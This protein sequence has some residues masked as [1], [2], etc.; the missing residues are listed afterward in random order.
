[1]QWTN[2]T[3]WICSTYKHAACPFSSWSAL[4]LQRT[5]LCFVKSYLNPCIIRGL[6]AVLKMGAEK[7][8]SWAAFADSKWKADSCVFIRL[9]SLSR[10]SFNRQNKSEWIRGENREHSIK[11][12]SAVC[13]CFPFAVLLFKWFLEMSHLINYMSTVCLSKYL[14]CSLQ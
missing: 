2:Q 3:N 4:Q 6:M 1:M 14:S 10:G 12:A 13:L 7:E 8:A 5:T 11:D 9:C